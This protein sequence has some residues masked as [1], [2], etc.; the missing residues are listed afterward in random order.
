MK[1]EKAPWSTEGAEAMALI[2]LLQKA[3]PKPTE[4]QAAAAR[5]FAL[6]ARQHLAS[7]GNRSARARYGVMLVAAA[8][9][10]L[11][12]LQFR[13]KLASEPALSYRTQS[14]ASVGQALDA[15][16]G[17][18]ELEFSDG[19]VVTVERGSQARVAE[20]TS[21]GARFR[22]ESGRML[23]DVVPH[24]D[25]GNWLVDAGPF[26]VR[27]TGTVFS[28]EWLEAED[29]LRVDVTRGHVVVEGAGQRRELGA[30]DSYQHRG[31]RAGD[32]SA[33][34]S[35][36]AVAPEPSVVAPAP[37]TSREHAVERSEPWSRLVTEGKFARVIAAAERRG[38]A[39]CLAACSR[40]DLRAF[41]D[42]ARLGGRPELSER[43]LLAQRSRF[44]GSSDAASAAFLLGRSAEARG[45]AQAS[46]WYDRYLAEA[47]NGRFASDALGRKMTFTAARDPKAGAALAQQ[48]LARFPAG[49]YA[50]HAQAL[51]EAAKRG[52]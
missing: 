9:L 32:R 47:P 30:G 16:K 21:R 39:N 35:A 40:E 4:N 23:F 37:S 2:G 22:L 26:Q 52:Q 12:A 28:V 15:S 25:R 24:A 44:A 38:I 46:T 10:V 11:L 33:P 51:L 49:A 8:A 7:Q 14:G 19:T 5:Q 13:G 20:T 1:Q 48:Y 36:T 27:V 43:A 17:P 29:S 3:D 42:A 50:A 34:P 31:P 45:D 41:S 6:S 18:L